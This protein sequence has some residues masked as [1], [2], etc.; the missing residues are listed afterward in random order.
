MSSN[1]IKISGRITHDL[2]L[3]TINN[4]N[5]LNFTIAH[6]H[7]F[8]DKASTMFFRCVCFGKTAEFITKH[9]SKGSGIVVT[10]DLRNNNYE[11]NGQKHYNVDINVSSVDF[12]DGNASINTVLL[13][14]NLVAEPQTKLNNGDKSVARFLVAARKNYKVAENKPSADFI[15][16]VTFGKQAEA[17]SKYLS[18]GS[19][20]DIKGYFSVRAYDSTDITGKP[21]KKYQYDVIV[22]QFGLSFLDKKNK[23]EANTSQEIRPIQSTPSN[24][25]QTSYVA[26]PYFVLDDD[27]DLPF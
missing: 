14:G 9:F 13:T 8:G 20:V 27:D 4:V 7:G 16:V 15:N 6:T 1:I 12:M 24:S 10:G 11:K 3:Q 17:A 26:S 23:D 2:Q 18:K 22:D 21:I 19:K 25:P 5:F